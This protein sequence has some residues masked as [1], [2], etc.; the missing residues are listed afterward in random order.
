M[1]IDKTKIKPI[2]PNTEIIRKSTCYK[3]VSL[4]NSL[5]MAKANLKIFLN[6][7]LDANR[8]V[9]RHVIYFLK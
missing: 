6:A 8:L 7:E 5:D 1:R 4:W 3:A 2:K 9:Y